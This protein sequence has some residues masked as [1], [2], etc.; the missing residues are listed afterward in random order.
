MELY[1]SEIVRFHGIPLSIVSDRNPRFTSRFWKELQS[2]FGTR[3]NFSIAFHP[4]T[5]GQSERVI[6]VLEDMLRGCVLD[7]S[8]SWDRYI[9]LM[10]FSY[11][12]NY[13]SSIGMAPYEALYERR[14]RTPM[15]WTELHEHEIIS[16]DLVKDTEEK[17]R[18]IQQRLK[19]SSDRQ[20]LMPV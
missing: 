13:Q 16:L 9:Q 4:Q 12:N 6:Q 17:V 5:D 11:N 8:G 3:L 19:A 20:Y 18:I 10:E 14:C 1:V 7:F 15:C 2:T